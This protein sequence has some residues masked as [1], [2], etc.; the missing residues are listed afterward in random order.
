[1]PVTSR[2]APW[3]QMEHNTSAL[4]IWWPL[5]TR[6][7]VGKG[8]LH[9]WGNAIFVSPAPGLCLIQSGAWQACATCAGKG[10]EWCRW[11]ASLSRAHQ[12]C[13]CF[14]LHHWSTFVNCSIFFLRLKLDTW[15]Y[16]IIPPSLVY[17]SVCVCVFFCSHPIS[18]GCSL[19]FHCIVFSCQTFF[20]HW[21]ASRY[22]QKVVCDSQNPSFKVPEFGAQWCLQGRELPPRKNDGVMSKWIHLSLGLGPS[23]LCFYGILFHKITIRVIT[24]KLINSRS[25][26]H[27]L[28]GNT[29][30]PR[31]VKDTPKVSWLMTEPGYCALLGLSLAAAP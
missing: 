13:L 7:P 4:F 25:P 6:V 12:K 3:L 29:L 22:S 14:D 11:R 5:A 19:N 21:R 24:C 10:S 23:V 9:V 17:L 27:Y 8:Q 15:Y 16:L 18:P 30:R 20:F 31:E 1:M 28:I 2:R 26:R